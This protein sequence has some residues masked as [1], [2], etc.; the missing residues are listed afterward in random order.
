[1]GKERDRV[2]HDGLSKRSLAAQG[3]VSGAK[4]RAVPWGSGALKGELKPTL[5]LT[6][7]QEGKV[8]FIPPHSTAFHEMAAAIRDDS[9]AGRA[10]SGLS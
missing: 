7:P 8:G 5:L 4:T 6:A 1:M 10:A 3:P 2:L 9:A